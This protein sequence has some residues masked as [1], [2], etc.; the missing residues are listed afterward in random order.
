MRLREAFSVLQF[1]QFLGGEE[2]VAGVVGFVGHEVEGGGAVVEIA[3][4][5]F[6]AS[7]AQASD[8]APCGEGDF[9]LPSP[10]V[11]HD[12]C[13][14]DWHVVQGLAPV[15]KELHNSVD[16]LGVNAFVWFVYCFCW[17]RLSLSFD[18]TKR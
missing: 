14:F 4:G 10:H 17:M 18:A 5:S 6:S 7:E 2:P 15:V 3:E 16:V 13:A 8:F 11:S 1:L 9:G 12:A